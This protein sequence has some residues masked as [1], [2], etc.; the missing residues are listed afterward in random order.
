M[1]KKMLAT[2]VLVGAMLVLPASAAFAHDC[3]IVNRSSQGAQSA[4]HSGRWVTFDMAATFAAAGVTSVEGAMAD[5]L[6]QGYK[7]F[8]ASRT[9]TLLGAN[10]SNPN[11]G[12]GKGLDHFSKSPVFVALI[13]TV[14]KWGGN[15]A[16]IG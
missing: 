4:A 16:L 12:N 7:A 3:F 11:L 10:S 9:D 5:W 13:N 2:I 6:G 1:G 8:Y 15:P 14:L